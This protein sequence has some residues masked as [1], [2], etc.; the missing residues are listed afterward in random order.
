MNVGNDDSDAD[1]LAKAFA[2]AEASGFALFYSFD[3]NYFSSPGS[4]DKIS[5]TYMPFAAS[6]AYYTVD[7]KLLVSTF[8]GE[9]SGTFLD[10]A[11]GF[12]ESNAKWKTML[13][14]AA[15]TLGKEIAFAPDWNDVS[16]VPQ[17]KYGGGIM[18]WAAWGEKGRTDDMTTA[19]DETYLSAAQENGLFYIAP[20]AAFFFVHVAAGNNYVL[21]SDWLLPK[22]YTDLI[23]LENG[24]QFVELLSWND[25][26][27]SHYLGPLRDDAGVPGAA[28]TYANTDHDH[29][30]ALAERVYRR[31]STLDNVGM[32]H[33]V[34]PPASR[35]RN[36][37]LRMSS[38]GSVRS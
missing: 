28:A 37:L 8:S 32:H 13:D 4:S 7:D 36:R 12:E 14:S 6:S 21:Q 3:M 34:F 11:N 27:E 10:G 2:A 35:R 38:N 20:V 26:G 17:Q 30:D 24:P 29:T 9:T 25:F 19:G 15:V 31:L 16:L 22:H 18:S 5:S 23:N 33:L 1:Q